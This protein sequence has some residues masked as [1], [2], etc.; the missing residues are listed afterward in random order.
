MSATLVEFLSN[1]Y[2]LK[3]GRE[4]RKEEEQEKWCNNI[5]TRG[6]QGLKEQQGCTTG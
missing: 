2:F 3:M 4:K 6:G 5:K 1:G